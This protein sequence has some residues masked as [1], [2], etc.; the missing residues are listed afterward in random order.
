MSGV[1]TSL[2]EA[3]ATAARGT[4]GVHH[5]SLQI[6]PHGLVGSV[7]DGGPEDEQRECLGE[8]DLVLHGPGASVIHHTPACSIVCLEALLTPAFMKLIICSCCSNSCICG[9]H[10]SACSI[11]NLA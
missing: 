6:S 10:A 3:D 8:V 7:Q 1:R 4:E 11:C 9:Q 5:G 2:T